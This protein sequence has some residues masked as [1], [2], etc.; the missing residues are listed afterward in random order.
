MNPSS[1][2]QFSSSPA[3]SRF[4]S[5][6]PVQAI[7][8]I[9]RMLTVGLSVPQLIRC[10]VQIFPWPVGNAIRFNDA[11]IS[12]SDH[13]VA[14]VRI[15][16]RASSEATVFAGSWLPNPHLGVLAAAP[17][18][19]QDDFASCVI[20]VGNDLRDQCAQKWLSRSHGNVR[21][22]P[23]GTQILGQSAEVGHR[24]GRRGHT[25][26]LQSCFGVLY[27]MQC[28]FP[29]FLELGC[30]QAIVRIAGG[31]APFG[32]RGLI[33]RLLQLEFYDA[34]LLALDI[35]VT[36]LGLDCRLIRHRLERTQQ[37]PRHRCLGSVAAKGRAT[38]TPQHQVWPIAA[39]D[40]R[41]RA[42]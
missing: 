34:L 1:A 10:A 22:I 17:T 20:H 35:H 28:D 7:S 27:A 26:R 30:D 13:R 24:C 11:A 12:S 3:C 9:K 19:G 23:R 14:T 41:Q 33:L 36:L 8:E 37:L 29:A 39:I 5:I 42:P 21:C 40:H 16:A 2:P 6:D 32:E 38:R 4:R 15:T 18:D 31:I 25:H